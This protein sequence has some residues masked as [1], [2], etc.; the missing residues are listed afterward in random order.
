ML[1][2]H[3]LYVHVYKVPIEQYTFSVHFYPNSRE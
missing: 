3:M 1:K 2:P